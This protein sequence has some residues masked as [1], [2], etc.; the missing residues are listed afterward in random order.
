[1][2]TLAC[3][4][5]MLPRL[6]VIMSFRPLAAWLRFGMESVRALDGRAPVQIGRVP[7]FGA[8]SGEKFSC[9][10]IAFIRVTVTR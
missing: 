3:R 8:Y 4:V 6:R 2:S 10:F 9:Y 7:C 5:N 1:M